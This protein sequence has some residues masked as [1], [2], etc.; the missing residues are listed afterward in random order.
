MSHTCPGLC[1]HEVAEAD[2]FACSTC[3]RELP[4]V[5]RVRIGATYWSGRWAAHSRALSDALLY[6]SALRRKGKATP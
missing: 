4:M 6:L 5:L 2:R 3:I 1:G